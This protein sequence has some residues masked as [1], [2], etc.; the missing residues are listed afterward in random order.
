LPPPTHEEIVALTK[1][2]DR[3][4]EVYAMLET[5]NQEFQPLDDAKKVDA[6][7]V[8]IWEL[9]QL[10]QLL[11]YGE[12]ESL[13]PALNRAKIAISKSR[14][15][16]ADNVISGERLGYPGQTFIT[17]YAAILIVFNADVERQK[18]PLRRPTL[19]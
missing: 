18:W 1:T 7:G 13:D 5:R 12:G 10:R 11:G 14:M 9:D 2:V 19:P 16:L 3:L 15:K 8:E 6:N 17:K 4:A